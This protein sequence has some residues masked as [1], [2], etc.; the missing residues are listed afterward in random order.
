MIQ[1]IIIPLLAI[2]IAELGDKSQIAV[3]CLASKTKEYW[4]LFLGVM[5]AFAITD[6]L[7]VIFGGVIT[8]IVPKEI[9]IGLSGLAF[10]V[11]GVMTLVSKDEDEA[12]CDLKTPFMSSFLLILMCEMGD[13]TQIVAGLF[14]TR[15][16]PYLVFIG[17]MI[18]MGILTAMAIYMGKFIVEKI[19]HKKISLISGIMFIL[20]GIWTILGLV[21]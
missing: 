3:F 18:A 8:E 19:S 15:Y 2:G 7:A 11:I 16:N 1:D 20:I 21:L 14:A 10:L 4:K 5:L 13:K 9:I 17:V 12:S 6:A